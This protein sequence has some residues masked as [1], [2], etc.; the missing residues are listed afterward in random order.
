MLSFT[1]LQ[2]APR[3]RCTTATGGLCLIHRTGSSCSDHKAEGCATRVG[4]FGAFAC[5]GER[6]M[7]PLSHRTA[8]GGGM[9]P[10]PNT[11][12]VSACC[13]NMLQQIKRGYISRVYLSLVSVWHFHLQ[14][15][16]SWSCKQMISLLF[17][18]AGAATAFW[19]ELYSRSMVSIYLIR[20]CHAAQMGC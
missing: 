14:N 17:I 5:V 7:A 12:L 8:E 19:L 20:W 16:Y 3:I 11:F 15:C 1:S 13:F 9:D 6:G 2:V 4:F 18:A 10:V